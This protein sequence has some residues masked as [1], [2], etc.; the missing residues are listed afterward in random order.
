MTKNL[1]LFEDD[2]SES[3]R[4]AQWK[5]KHPH[6]E[7]DASVETVKQP[8]DK[9]AE[10][11]DFYQAQRD[12]AHN[13]LPPQTVSGK[14]VEQWLVTDYRGNQGIPQGRIGVIDLDIKTATGNFKGVSLAEVIDN[15]LGK[16]AHVIDL[17]SAI[18]SAKQKT[19]QGL[20]TG[21]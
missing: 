18:A 19:Q 14:S 10:V 4:K 12:L 5:L 20:P 11:K 3:W 8:R 9:E 16:N 6:K 21:S 17:A 2:S 1:D 15:V 13:H 7:S